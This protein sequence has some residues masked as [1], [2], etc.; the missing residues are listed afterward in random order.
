VYYLYRGIFGGFSYISSTI[1]STASSAVPQI[2]LCRRKSGSNP[3]PLQHLHWESY[4]LTTRLD[5]IQTKLDLIQY[6]LHWRRKGEHVRVLVQYILYVHSVSCFHLNLSLKCSKNYL[7]Q[8][9]KPKWLVINKKNAWSSSR[10]LVEEKL[11]C[12]IFRKDENFREMFFFRIYFLG[13]RGIGKM[14]CLLPQNYLTKRNVLVF[15]N[16]L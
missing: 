14:L 4:A 15:K 16:L 6:Y 8:N 9:P 13:L 3:G 10:I 11:I 12:F 1:F 2:P 5:L 7:M